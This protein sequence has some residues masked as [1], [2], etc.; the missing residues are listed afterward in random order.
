MFPREIYDNPVWCEYAAMNGR[1]MI[2]YPLKRGQPVPCPHCGK[3]LAFAKYKAT[4]CGHEFGTSFHEVY[5]REPI[6]THHKTSGRGWE[7]LRPWK[8]SAG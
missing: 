6:E 2:K 8:Q 3:P 4:C 7:S 5:R 1:V